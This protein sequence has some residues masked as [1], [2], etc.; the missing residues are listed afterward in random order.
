M[1][2]LEIFTEPFFFP[3][4]VTVGRFRQIV[5]DESLGQR[6]EDYIIVAVGGHSDDEGMRSRHDRQLAS[7][8]ALAGGNNSIAV[9]K[10]LEHGDFNLFL[11]MFVEKGPHLRIAFSE[12]ASNYGNIAPMLQGEGY[13]EV[14]RFM[15]NSM[16]QIAPVLW[17]VRRDLNLSPFYPVPQSADLHALLGETLG[18]YL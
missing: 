16:H 12:I 14:L 7:L 11:M 18:Q 6:L 8:T 1:S 9:H 10:A 13:D 4:Q 17:S 15:S 5:P 3:E 2:G